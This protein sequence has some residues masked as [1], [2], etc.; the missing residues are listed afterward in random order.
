MS[1]PISTHAVPTARDATGKRTWRPTDITTTPPGFS[2]S[3]LLCGKCPAPVKAIHNHTRG[4]K[5]VAAF[6]SLRSAGPGAPSASHADSCEYNVAAA[7]DDLRARLEL[8]T[9]DAAGVDLYE[10]VMDHTGI[11]AQVE[12][13][14]PAA[15]DRR[16]RHRPATTTRFIAVRPKLLDD[17]VKI[18]TLVHRYRDDPTAAHLFTLRWGTYRLSWADFYYPPDRHPALVDRAVAAA[19]AGSADVGPLVVTG[20]ITTISGEK[21]GKGGLY[22]SVDLGKVITPTGLVPI[23]V[24]DKPPYTELHVGQALLVLNFW[25]HHVMQS[26]FTMVRAFTPATAMTTLEPA[27]LAPTG[28]DGP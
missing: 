12:T 20:T 4:G 26:G 17:L 10:L 5:P 1:P 21:K 6:F 24:Q 18:V 22:R 2:T 23:R 14:A 8:V 28:A 9:I 19:A 7:V 16:V 3:G 15:L 11:L 27:L 13:T 25:A